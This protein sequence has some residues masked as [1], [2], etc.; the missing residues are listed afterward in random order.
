LPY[1]IDLS[2][3]PRRRTSSSF[4]ADLGTS[5]LAKPHAT[6]RINGVGHVL[7]VPCD[8]HK[9]VQEITAYPARHWA[10]SDWSAQ[11]SSVSINRRPLSQA[12]CQRRQHDAQYT[13]APGATGARPRRARPAW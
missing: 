3:A 5:L 7:F 12:H 13:P 8:V 9:S 6:S 2:L 1:R 11:N 10:R 4:R